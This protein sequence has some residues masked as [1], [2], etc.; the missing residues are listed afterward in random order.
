MAVSINVLNQSLQRIAVVDDYT[1]LIWAKRY[2][3]VGALDLQVEATEKNLE[4]FRKY[5]YITRDDDDAVYRIEALEL[6][7][8]VDQTNYII[9]GAFDCKKI[10]NQ[11]IVWRQL[12]FTGTVENFI[13]RI[14][15]DNIINPDI[16]QRRI[17]NFLLHA[18]PPS[19]VWA[20]P[21][22]STSGF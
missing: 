6:D 12:N 9:V 11:R 2:Y 20:V 15:T 8:S 5:N 13:R 7:T 21:S 14:I 4:I 22:S 10:L 16:S 17:N 3:E 19:E 18:I 1:S